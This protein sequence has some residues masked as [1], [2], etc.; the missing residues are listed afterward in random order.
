M[1]TNE[2][3]YLIIAGTKFSGWK[4]TTITKSIESCCGK[5]S[6]SLVTKTDLEMASLVPG[7]PCQVYI[8]KDLVIDGYLDKVSPTGDES[9]FAYTIEGRD[10]TQDLIDCSCERAPYTWTEISLYALANKLCAP[11]NILVSK[12]GVFEDPRTKFTLEIG[13]TA[14]EALAKAAKARNVLLMANE[15]GNLVIGKPGEERLTDSLV[16]GKNLKKFSADYDNTN[17][18]HKYVVKGQ[19]TNNGNPWSKSSTNIYG[20]AFDEEVRST[21]V[22]IFSADNAESNATAKERAKWEAIKNAALSEQIEVLVVG[23][24]QSNGN[25]WKENKLVPVIIDTKAIYIN[26]EMLVSSV[27]Y[28]SN[29]AGRT[30]SMTLK[31]K[32]AYTEFVRAKV[33]KKGKKQGINLS[34]LGA[35]K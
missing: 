25:L 23:F 3:V 30:T 22:K 7:A 4:T 2:Q 8:G 20:E 27:T 13:E 16:Y 26:T 33:K 14:F 5:F 21:R 1:S 11:Y 28:S 34:A 24:R 35:K 10:K 15:E 18:F 19:R 32:D 9:G 29:E 31:R 17:R 12:S 6:F